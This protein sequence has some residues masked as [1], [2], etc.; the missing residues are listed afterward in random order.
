M[1]VMEKNRLLKQL[2]DLREY[3]QKDRQ[4]AVSRA[5]ELLLDYF[6]KTDNDINKAYRRVRLYN[7]NKTK[8]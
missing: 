7:P 6:L 1:R 3:A 2:L 8:D 4:V 5:E